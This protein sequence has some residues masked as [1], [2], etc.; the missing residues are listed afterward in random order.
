MSHILNG[1]TAHGLLRPP[2]LTYENI[3][4]TPRGFQD[5]MLL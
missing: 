1:R 4:D 5:F 2:P 3:T